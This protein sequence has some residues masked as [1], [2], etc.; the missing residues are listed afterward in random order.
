[1]QS[2]S[3]FL[4]IAKFSDFQRKKKVDFSKNQEVRRVICIFSESSLGKI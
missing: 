3:V 4:E 2:T 1:M